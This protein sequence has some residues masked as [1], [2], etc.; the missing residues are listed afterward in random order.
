M[1]AVLK[2]SNVMPQINTL[3]WY[4]PLYGIVLSLVH[5]KWI[6]LCL[7]HFSLLISLQIQ[8]TELSNVNWIKA[9]IEISHSLNHLTPR[10]GALALSEPKKKRETRIKCTAGYCTSCAQNSLHWM[11]LCEVCV[12]LVVHSV[13]SVCLVSRWETEAVEAAAAHNVATPHLL[14]IIPNKQ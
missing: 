10:M 14:T 13:C 6:R 3:L 1:Y 8:S 5:Y 9:G 11:S 4:H 12:V 7:F 2:S